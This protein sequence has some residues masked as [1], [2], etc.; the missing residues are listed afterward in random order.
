MADRALITKKATIHATAL[1]DGLV[2]IVKRWLIG[3]VSHLARMA[4]D[5]SNV[6]RALNANAKM[7]GPEKCAM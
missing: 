3:A 7:V 1:L 6:E 5:A 2:L 4:L